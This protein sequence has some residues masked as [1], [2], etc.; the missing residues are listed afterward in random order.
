MAK[1]EARKSS[2]NSKARVKRELAIPEWSALA[3]LVRR[4]SEGV[5]LSC[6]KPIREHYGRK[7]VWIGCHAPDVPATATFLL[8]PVILPADRPMTSGVRVGGRPK[9]AAAEMQVIHRDQPATRVPRV[10]PAPKATP[11]APEPIAAPLPRYVYAAKDKRRSLVGASEAVTDAYKGLLKA[12]KPVDAVH[13][14]KLAKRPTEANR[15]CLNWL[16]EQGLATKT[17]TATN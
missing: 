8:V 13:A 1:R 14:A 17:N 3:P 4:G 6:R 2:T 16:V 12:T 10:E 9:Q 15:R 11:K 5:C 7:G